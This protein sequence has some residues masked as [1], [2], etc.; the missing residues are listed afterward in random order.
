[1][2]GIIFLYLSGIIFPTLL[3]RV[4]VL[5]FKYFSSKLNPHKAS[6]SVIFFSIIRGMPRDVAEINFLS[7]AKWLDLYGVEFQKVLVNTIFSRRLRNQD[8]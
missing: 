2:F 4:Y 1:M 8:K 5:P 6:L 3:L 7:K